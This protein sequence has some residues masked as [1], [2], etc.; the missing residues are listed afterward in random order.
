V[1][2]ILAGALGVTALA[3][4]TVA[5]VRPAAREREHVAP[6]KP[7]DCDT[8]AAVVRA[9]PNDRAMAENPVVVACRRPPGPPPGPPTLSVVDAL[10]LA[11][12][13]EVLRHEV[14]DPRQLQTRF[15]FAARD[16][17][18]TWKTAVTQTVVFVHESGVVSGARCSLDAATP[19]TTS[20]WQHV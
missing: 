8:V 6:A 5:A 20:A 19:C 17:V 14:V 1:F 12:R 15:D 2:A 13:Y 18:F 9:S 11:E 16:W 3:F 10:A 7:M 4:E